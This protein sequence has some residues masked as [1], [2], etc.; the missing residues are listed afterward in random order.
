MSLPIL[1]HPEQNDAILK[2][3]GVSLAAFL[4]TV[5]LRKDGTYTVRLRLTY[6]R[7]PK[8]YTTKINLSIEEY[9]KMLGRRPRSDLKTKLIIISELLKKANDIIVAMSFFSFE[10]FEKKFLKR[11]GM[12]SDVFN[13][14]ESHIKYLKE[15]GQPGTA[16]TY[17]TA[18]NSFKKF[19]RK[20]KL[21][22]DQVNVKWLNDY[23]QWMQIEGKSNT[24]ISINTRCLRRLYNL[25]IYESA[26]LRD[27]YPFGN[28]ESGLYRPPEHSNYKKALSKSEIKKIYDYKPQNGSQEHFNRDLWL[29]SYLCNGMN[30]AD[31]FRLRYKD[32]YDD[33]IVFIRHKTAHQR[34]L[35][36]VFVQIT[37][38]I[39]KIIER[40]G[41]IPAFNENY[42]FNV[43]VEGLTPEQEMAKIKQATKICNKY[44]KHIA[45]KIGIDENIS[46]YYARHSYASVLKLA[47]ENIA[48]ISESLGHSNLQVTENYLSSFDNTK[49]KEASKKLTDWD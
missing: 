48:Y 19:F 31:I 4:D 26:A 16:S 45:L 13:S 7:F 36:P 17:N 42:V 29:F 11:Q 35:K 15:N 47:G 33:T 46:T 32:I 40:W 24:T 8:Y 28:S 49:R 30:M 18:L 22:F 37:P 14:F 6:R 21:R 44:M 10:G 27:L 39:Q 5:R 43:L 34:R 3:K 20:N 1:T 2:S 38:D 25:A 12:S 23:E 9:E 41:N